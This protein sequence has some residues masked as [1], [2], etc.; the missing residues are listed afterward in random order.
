MHH[1]PPPF[2]VTESHYGAL[3]ELELMI[4][5]REEVSLKLATVSPAYAS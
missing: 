3:T 1:V 2:F 4:L 5:T